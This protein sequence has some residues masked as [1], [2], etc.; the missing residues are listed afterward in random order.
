[1]SP[2]ATILRGYAILTLPILGIFLACTMGGLVLALGTMDNSPWILVALVAAL[3]L[4]TA[5]GWAYWSW[6]VVR[7]RV[8]AFAKTPR[9]QWRDLYLRAVRM[10]LIWPRGHRFERTEWRGPR[11]RAFLAAVDAFLEDPPTWVT[12]P[13]PLSAVAD[14]PG[15]PA[16]T[17]YRH[18]R[19]EAPLSVA[20]FLAFLALGV[21]LIRM[22]NYV[23]GVLAP[24]I[25]ARFLYTRWRDGVFSA[26]PQCSLSDHGIALYA[27][28]DRGTVPWSRTGDIAVDD[29]LNLLELD[30]YAADGDTVETWTVP[31]KEWDTGGA[32]AL[33]KRIDRY[34]RRALGA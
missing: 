6:A 30:V 21:W 24:L 4:G 2:T 12:E 1:M 3:V 27:F 10:Q 33:R 31:F 8:W 15:V 28:R 11:E 9:A 5:L 29:A 23:I 16:V 26:T 22:G 17:H 19:F 20:I 32:E 13:P 25:M 7:W 14:D 34:R 18:K